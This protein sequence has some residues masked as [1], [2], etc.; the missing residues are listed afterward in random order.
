M[1]PLSIKPHCRLQFGYS[2]SLRQRG[3]Q[4]LSFEGCTRLDMSRSNK[5]EAEGIPKESSFRAGKAE[6]ATSPLYAAHIP[7]FWVN[8][9]RIPGISIVVCDNPAPK[10]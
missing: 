5:V 3:L 1:K 7:D 8:D 2:G 6:S 10:G 4:G 9:T